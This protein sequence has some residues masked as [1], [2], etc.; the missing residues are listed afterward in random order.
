M[1]HSTPGEP[2]PCETPSLTAG[3]LPDPPPGGKRPANL[4][5]GGGAQAPPQAR[6][7]AL[8]ALHPNCSLLGLR[9]KN[10][11]VFKGI[12]GEGERG[13]WQPSRNQHYD[14]AIASYFLWLFLNLEIPAGG[15]VRIK[16]SKRGGSAPRMSTKHTALMFLLTILAT[17]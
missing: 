10:H 6:R 1:N 9:F 4:G 14:N 8:V 5:E 17:G 15:E 11:P 2:F 13:M 7:R 3:S 16:L 12:G